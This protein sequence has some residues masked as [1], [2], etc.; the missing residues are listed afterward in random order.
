MFFNAIFSGEALYIG[1]FLS[2]I[3]DRIHFLI[4]TKK[5]QDINTNNKKPRTPEVIQP[6]KKKHGHKLPHSF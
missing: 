4:Q 6:T 1:L 5:L 3:L 2:C